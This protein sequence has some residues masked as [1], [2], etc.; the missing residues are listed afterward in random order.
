MLSINK[1]VCNF[2][3]VTNEIYL[4]IIVNNS[5]VEPMREVVYL[6]KRYYCRIGIIIRSLHFLR[7]NEGSL[8]L[9]PQIK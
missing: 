6:F 9:W 8:T 7:Y 2:L 5:C 3:F 4:Y 1:T